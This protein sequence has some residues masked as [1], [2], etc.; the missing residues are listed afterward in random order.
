MRRPTVR[1]VVLVLAALATGACST[2]LRGD[3]PRATTTTRPASAAGEGWRPLAD[4]P[5]TPRAG[6]TAVWTGR[7]MVLWGGAG[8]A[9]GECAAGNATPM[10]DGAAYNPVRDTWRRIAASPLR[11]RSDAGHVWTGREVLNWGG[12][13]TTGRLFADGAAY[14]PVTDT[15]KAMAASPLTARA[16]PSVAWTGREMLVWG[17]FAGTT[18]FADGAAYDP[19][20]DT[21]RRLADSPL[22]GRFGVARWTGTLWLRWGGAGE[23]AEGSGPVGDGASYDPATDTW[24]RLPASPL[25]ARSGPARAWTGSEFLIVGGSAGEER[26]AD[27]AAYRPEANRWR[28]VPAYPGTPRSSFVSEWTGQ[29]LLLWGGQAGELVLGSGGAYDPQTNR[30]RPLPSAKPRAAPAWVWTGDELI[31]WGGFT[32]VVGV[33]TLATASDGLRLVP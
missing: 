8:C 14:N 27:G 25:S 16:D 4:S 7:E 29:E 12:I 31:V 22:S 33:G 3:A 28:A 21:W 10:S 24:R 5:L 9:G 32:R 30:W 20:A 15:W 18:F 11:P 2:S 17:G 23:T 26:F 1:L 13:G 19:E 6:A